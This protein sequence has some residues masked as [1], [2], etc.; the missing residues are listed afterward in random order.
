VVYIQYVPHE[1]PVHGC[2]WQPYFPF[3]TVIA[4]RILQGGHLYHSLYDF[5]LDEK[6]IWLISDV[7]EL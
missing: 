3:F 4:R 6:A 2:C 5:K 7:D 1:K